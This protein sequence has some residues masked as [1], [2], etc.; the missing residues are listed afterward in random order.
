MVRLACA[1]VPAFPLQLLL[2]RH[3]EWRGQPVAVVAEDKPQGLILW[4]DEKARRAGVLSGLRYAA[5]LSLTPHLR[6]G[7]VSLAE[8]EAEIAA[9]TKRLGRFTPD[10]EPSLEE[11][12]VFWLSGAGLGRLHPSR[13]QWARAI[14]SDLLDAGF[15]A[16]VVAGFTRFGTLAVARARRGTVVFE[17]PAHER[18]AAGEVPLDRLELDSRLRDALDRL[19]IRS[20]A[21]LLRLP[22]GGLLER[23]G[24]EAYRLHRMAAGELW[25]P[26][27]PRVDEEPI[28]ERLVL[29]APEIEAT[30]LLFFAKGLLHPLLAALATRGEAVAELTL[31]FALDDKE[32]RTE[33]I[34]PAAPTLDAKQVLDLVR[35]RLEAAELSAGVVEI[36]LTARGSP[37]EPKQLRFFAEQPRRDLDAANQ[38]LA[39]LRA[40]FGDEAVVRA[41]LTGGHLPEAS[42]AWEPLDQVAPPRPR[43][44]TLRTLVRRVLAKPVPLPSHARQLADEEWLTLEARHGPVK[45]L[46]G[47]YIVS[48]SWWMR[49]VH[50]E[51]HFAEIQ[52]GDLLWVYYDRHARR[53]FLHGQ[54]V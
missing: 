14:R 50:R 17:D 39:R 10:V 52:P 23:F 12:G 26:L 20:V 31:H 37:V 45:R 11:P 8:I 49:E 6:A 9:L 13:E 25:M 34:R 28:R 53:W 35:L 30:R 24:F 27:Q 48:G 3:P 46:L 16:T 40:E 18:A 33:P 1:S 51:Y 4:V 29:D 21:A 38:A 7:V 54:V 5:G 47:P 36:E 32:R 15:R 42:F 19:G 22:A 43:E 41:K 2:R 44:V